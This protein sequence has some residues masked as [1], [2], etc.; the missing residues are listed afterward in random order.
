M[1]ATYRCFRITRKPL[2][3][4][5]QDFFTPQA[6]CSHTTDTNFSYDRHNFLIQQKLFFHTVN[7]IFSHNNQAR[8]DERK[9]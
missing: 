3:Q 8:N 6:R 1:I 7:K 9:Q 2:K 5:R 4:R